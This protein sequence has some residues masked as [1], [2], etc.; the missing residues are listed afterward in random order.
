MAVF[1]D[2]HGKALKVVPGIA[3]GLRTED[4]DGE[5]VMAITVN[6]DAA[7]EGGDGDDIYS[8]AGDGGDP[9]CPA[10]GGMFGSWVK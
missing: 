1:G 8:P 9:L 10:K 2:S 4:N 5:P 3:T 6:P 7:V